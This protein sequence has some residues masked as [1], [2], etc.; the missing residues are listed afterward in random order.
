MDSKVVIL[1]MLTYVKSPKR[2]VEKLVKCARKLDVE[3][4][5]QKLFGG[6]SVRIRNVM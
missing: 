4:K 6:I 1:A 2:D 3:K 5:I